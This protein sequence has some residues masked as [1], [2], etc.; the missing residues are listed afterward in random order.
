M[1]KTTRR[2]ALA[3]FATAGGL[4]VVGIDGFGGPPW[5]SCC[6]RIAW[7]ASCTPTSWASTSWPR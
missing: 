5:W 6:Y 1:T 2:T 7:A 4:Q 3:M